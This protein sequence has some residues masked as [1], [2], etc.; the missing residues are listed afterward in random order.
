MQVWLKTTKRF[1]FDLFYI[2]SFFTSDNISK[3]REE[4]LKNSSLNLLPKV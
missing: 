3:F 4:V 1:L 2:D